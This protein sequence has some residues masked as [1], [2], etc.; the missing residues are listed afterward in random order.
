MA[1]SARANV[2]P[3]LVLGIG[4]VGSAVAHRLFSLGYRV[5]MQDEAYPAYP[6][7]GMSFTDA[8]YDGK[9][10]LED[11]WSK[12]CGDTESLR[13]MRECGRAIPVLL[14]PWERCV[15]AVEARV[16]VDARMRKR[17]T[18]RSYRGRAAVTIGIGPGFDAGRNVDAAIES[19]WGETLGYV[20]LSGATRALEGEPREIMGVTRERFV[21]SACEGVFESRLAIGD[22]VES[23]QTIG[24]VGASAVIAPISGVLRGLTRPGILVQ[25]GAKIVEVDPRGD[26]RG[27]L[28]LGERPARIAQ[29]VVRALLTF[30]RS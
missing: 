30:E 22:R 9:C 12:R 8:A 10:I 4:D 28:G 6:R 23:G 27:C 7:R 5:A 17:E 16:L 18:P 24:I 13:R 11:V 29:G 26:P 19:G 3:V 20:I 2:G 25:Q 1:K 14:E 21:Y 15:S